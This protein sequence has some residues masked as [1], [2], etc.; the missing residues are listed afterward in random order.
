MLSIQTVL[1]L[2]FP[3]GH[4]TSRLR[5]TGG[6]KRWNWMQSCLCG[7]LS[8]NRQRVSV[9]RIIDYDSFHQM[10]LP[11]TFSKKSRTTIHTSTHISSDSI[12]EDVLDIISPIVSLLPPVLWPT[13]SF[14]PHIHIRHYLRSETRANIT[15]GALGQLLEHLLH[16]E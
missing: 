14:F 16:A 11:W 9:D 5:S 1:H 12:N 2:T 6:V 7:A 15:S 8:V 10:T 3:G 13:L 4:S